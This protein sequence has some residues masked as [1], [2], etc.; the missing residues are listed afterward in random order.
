ML[1]ALIYFLKN[2]KAPGGGL[3]GA[4]SN[5]KGLGGNNSAGPKEAS[6]KMGR[7]SLPYCERA[8]LVNERHMNSELNGESV[9]T[10]IS[11]NY[12]NS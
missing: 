4:S 1:N 8:P 3:G 2:F 9:K 7:L 12:V 5:P 10:K 6:G 11:P